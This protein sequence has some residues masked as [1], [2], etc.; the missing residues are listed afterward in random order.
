MW[1]KIFNAS[2]Y[3]QSKENKAS[4]LMTKGLRD[5]KCDLW[6][7]KVRIK[8][9]WAKPL[10]KMCRYNVEAATT[11]NNKE[12]CVETKTGNYTTTNDVGTF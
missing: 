2:V 10:K 11:C 1:K 3:K 8:F 6:N 9:E 5:D 12:N 4:E 7:K